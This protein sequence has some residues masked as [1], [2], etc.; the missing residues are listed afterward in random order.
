MYGNECVEGIWQKNEKNANGK[1]WGS[2]TLIYIKAHTRV[3]LIRSNNV[4]T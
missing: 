4:F 2:P 3:R 1:N